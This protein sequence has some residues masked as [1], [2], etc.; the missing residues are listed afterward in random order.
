MVKEV[1]AKRAKVSRVPTS[2]K[3]RK[4]TCHKDQRSLIGITVKDKVLQLSFDFNKV[5]LVW[6]TNKVIDIAIAVGL[7]WYFA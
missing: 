3:K 5:T 1:K 4:A 2:S 7:A 6:A